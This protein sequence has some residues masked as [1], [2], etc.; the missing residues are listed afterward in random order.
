MLGTGVD[1]RTSVPA[2]PVV[3]DADRTQLERVVINL[4]VNAS[5]AMPDGGP[6]EISVGDSTLTVTDRGCGIQARALERIFE[7]DYTTREHG[8]GIGLASVQTIVSQ[9]G[10]RISVASRPGEGSSFTV[11]LPEAA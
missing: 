5:N 7:P 6:L 11:H 10:G 1:L 2:R 3:V 9:L 4:A 8:H